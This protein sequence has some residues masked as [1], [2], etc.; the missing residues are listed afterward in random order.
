MPSPCWLAAAGLLLMSPFPV[1]AQTGT[2]TVDTVLARARRWLGPAALERVRSLRVSAV[3]NGPTGSLYA[4]IRSRFDGRVRFEQHAADGPKF[5]A[6]VGRSGPWT[7]SLDQGRAEPATPAVASVLVGHEY[8]LLT[9]YP[10]SRWTSP[11][12]VGR[13]VVEGDTLWRVNFKDRLGATVGIRYAEDGRPV[14]VLLVNHSGRGSP[15]VLVRLFDWPAGGTGPR[16]FRHAV[17]FHGSQTWLYHYL[18]VEADTAGDAAFEPS[19]PID[20]PARTE[21]VEGCH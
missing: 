19:V 21:S 7:W 18:T 4:V 16:L 10:A 11:E 1:A 13:E 12:L 9:A 20:A 17:I 5:I 15:E 3:V 14:E 6:G 2:V 8:H